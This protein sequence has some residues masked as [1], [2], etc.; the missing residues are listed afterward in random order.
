MK[1]L[2]LVSLCFL[3]LCVTQV[4]AQ[5]R[6]VTGTVTAKD[7]GLPIPGAT[8]KVKGTTTATVTNSAGKFSLTVPSGS[9]IV[10]SFVGYDTQTITVGSQTTINVSLI[11]AS[12]TLGE[13]VITTSMG[14]KHSAKELG[15]SATTI[16][17]KEL[18]Q[19]N[20][21][22]VAQG[23]TGK[24]AGLGIY[25]LDN[26]V[27][28]NIAINLRGNRSLEG[29]NSA[30]IVLDGV[31]IPGQTIGSINPNDIADVTIL[32]GAGA[33]SLYGSQASNGAILISTKR[34][35]ADGKPVIQYGNS[36]QYE[37]VA[38]YPKL[39]TGFGQ[40]GGET[41]YIDPLTGFS[42]YVPYENQLYGPPFN[43]ATV[44]IGPPLDSANGKV[45]TGIYAPY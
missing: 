21:T 27:D 35:N 13:V 12:A 42:E 3:M 6:T 8:V 41:S 9:S 22:N 11:T 7:D 5:N 39:Q 2:L 30:L 19:T 31:P 14:V 18:T 34:G 38:F 37:K 15:Y 1:K 10:V 16:T 32:K 26:G 43:G 23:L 25:T 24:V 45:I 29:N 4:F 33:A 28:P 20:V 36:F 17:P 40:Y 44:Q